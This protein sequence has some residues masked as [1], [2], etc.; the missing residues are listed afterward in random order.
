MAVERIET[1]IHVEDA[2]AEGATVGLGPERA[3][4]LKHV[5]RLAPGAELALFNGRDGEYRARLDG[6]GKGWASLAVLEQRRAPAPEPD[7]WLVFAPLKF[8]R[9]DFLAQKATELGVSALVPVFTRRTVVERVNLDRLRA[10]AVEAA[11]QS[12]R[13]SVP[14][15]HEA[16]RLDQAIG[17]WP[18]GRRLYVC[19]ERGGAVPIARAL[20]DCLAGPAANLPAAFL[21]GPEGGFDPAELD[22]LVKLPFVTPVSLG[23]RILRADTAALAALAVWQALRD[24]AANVDASG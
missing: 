19:A 22:A 16:R 18:E 23:R 8:A 3:H 15:V 24:A 2:L 4:F 9:I 20:A 5:L 1:R 21:I 14:E 17:H 6:V 7:L 11:E 12:E 13:L 10:N